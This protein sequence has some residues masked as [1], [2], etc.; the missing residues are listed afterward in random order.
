MLSRKRGLIGFFVMIKC[1]AS[2]NPFDFNNYGCWCGLGGKGKPLDEVD[3]CCR[4]HDNCYKSLRLSGACGV[5]DQQLPL[6]IYVRPYSFK[7][8]T[9]CEPASHYKQNGECLYGLCKC[10]ADAAKCFAKYE[11]K[12]NEKFKFHP[13]IFC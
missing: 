10:D 12:Y 3:S 4:D 2:R 9:V 8:C 6:T 1:K 13:K 11:D 5:I 7:E